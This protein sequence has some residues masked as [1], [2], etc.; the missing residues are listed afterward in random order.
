M[1]MD[2]SLFYNSL[3]SSFAFPT[4]LDGFLGV[5]D[6]GFWF[7]NLQWCSSLRFWCCHCGS[8]AF[9]VRHWNATWEM[10]TW[11]DLAQKKLNLEN[12]APEKMTKKTHRYTLDGGFRRLLQLRLR[13]PKKMI[14]KIDQNHDF[15][16]IRFGTPNPQNMVVF[17]H[18]FHQ[19]KTS[20]CG[21]VGLGNFMAEFFQVPSWN[22]DFSST[23]RLGWQL[24]H[25]G[26]R[27]SRDPSQI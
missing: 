10:Q 15:F 8:K 5:S 27:P 4:C 9:L 12:C 11:L 14:T 22:K 19:I 6:L 26:P 25:A 20:Q 2:M 3:G 18:F 23:S 13:F 21:C 24:P 7:Q 16:K 1:E 17:L